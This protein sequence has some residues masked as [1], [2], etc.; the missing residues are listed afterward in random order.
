M[1]AW[2]L[3]EVAISNSQVWLKLLA[4]CSSSV[5]SAAFFEARFNGTT[6]S[7]DRYRVVTRFRIQKSGG[8][9]PLTTHASRRRKPPFTAR[10][11]CPLRVI[12][13]H[14]NTSRN[15]PASHAFRSGRPGCIGVCRRP[16]SHRRTHVSGAMARF[17]G[18]GE[19]PRAYRT[20]GRARSGGHVPD[21]PRG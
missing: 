14:G 1:P 5:Q 11:R 21:G 13:G 20:T 4:S 19:R 3:Y 8:D 2:H 18:M 15:S 7:V 10:E 6:Y 12:N 9:E 17:P 16:G